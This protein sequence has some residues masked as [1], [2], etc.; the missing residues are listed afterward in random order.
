[1]QAAAFQRL[2]PGRLVKTP[3]GAL[4]FVPHSLPPQLGIT[5]ELAALISEAD[6]RLSELAGAAGTLPNPH[7]LIAPFSRKEAVLS[8]RIEGTLAS[9]SD[10]VSY[11]ALGVVPAERPDVREVAN[12]VAALEHGLRRLKE[13]P[14]S[15]RLVRELHERLTRGVRGQALMSGE[16]RTLQNWIGPP[17]C[18]IKE[19]TFVPPPVNEMRECLSALE[20]YLHQP[21]QLPHLVR[22]ALIHYQFEAIHPFL[23]GN[24]RIG[25]LLIT[26][27]L[28]ADGLLPQPLLYLSAFF[29]RY[30]SD[31]YRLLLEVSTRGKWWE[32]IAF[33]LRGVAAQ[34]ADALHRANR[35]QALA[36]QYRET[37]QAKRQ[38]ANLLKIVDHLF[39]R[40]VVTAASLA[41]LLRV[42]V[43]SAQGNIE[44][45]CGAGILKEVTGKRRGRIYVATNIL[46]VV[47]EEQPAQRDLQFKRELTLL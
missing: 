24:G 27:L 46:K 32:W 44:K 11:E 23:D 22:L 39:H 9:L 47:E 40:P 33:F 16:F 8:S 15:L 4:A 21:S 13:I 34:S 35:L 1:M 20:A 18:Q 38:S 31:Y 5:W 29:E 37:M 43:N 2:A 30:R 17:G 41:K 10:L 45:L 3:E 26:L 7:L 19:A 25:R 12:Y 6:R 42:T 28:V 36:L 14:V